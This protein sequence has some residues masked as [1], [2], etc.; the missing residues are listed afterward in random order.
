MGGEIEISGRNN[1][2]ANT[3]QPNFYRIEERDIALPEESR[4]EVR[5]GACV[6][7][8]HGRECKDTGRESIL[9]SC[10]S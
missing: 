3:C 10:S 4:L 8:L 6:L 2:L 5:A 9:L 7:Y 1:F